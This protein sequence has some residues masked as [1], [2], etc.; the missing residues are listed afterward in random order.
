MPSHSLMELGDG[1][2]T[3]ERLRNH[4]RKSSN[5]NS[6]HCQHP[7]STRNRKPAKYGICRYAELPHHADEAQSDSENEST[8]NSQQGNARQGNERAPE[9][10]TTE[11]C[12]SFQRADVGELSNGVD[13][14]RS[15]NNLRNITDQGR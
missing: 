3:M 9:T 6:K 13:H 11:F 10:P 8:E 14:D 4:R 5:G 2:V 7:Q 12:V 15:E 1:Y